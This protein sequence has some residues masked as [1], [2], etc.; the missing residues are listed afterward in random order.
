MK[1]LKG[2]VYLVGAGPGS[3]GLITVRGIEVLREA[4]VVLYDRLIHPYLL[5]FAPEARKIYCGKKPGKHVWDQERI[6][7]AL[8]REA[9]KEN[10]VVRLKGGD[11]FIFG[12]GGEE[13]I[14]LSRAQIPF[15]VVPG[16]SSA[17]GVPSSLGLPLTHRAKSSTLAIVTG[18]QDPTS[19]VLPIDWES[20]SSFETIVILM[21]VKALP[22][23]AKN[24]LKKKSPKTPVSIITWGTFPWQ[25]VVKGTL[26]NIVEKSQK[27]KVKPPSIIVVGKVVNLPCDLI[28]FKNFPH[29]GRRAFLIGSFDRVGDF[30]RRLID[31]GFQVEICNYKRELSDSLWKIV[32]TLGS[33]DWLIFKDPEAVEGLL[34]ALKEKKYDLRSLS[35]LGLGVMSE[36]ALEELKKSGLFADKVFSISEKFPARAIVIGS[37]E[38][39]G[40]GLEAKEISAFK[41]NLEPS[42]VKK[43][44]RKG[45]DFSFILSPSGVSVLSKIPG[46]RLGRVFAHSNCALPLREK[47]YSFIQF[48]S[49][50]QIEEF[51]YNY[52][53]EILKEVKL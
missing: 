22:E 42:I 39:G 16:I 50:S 20:V 38:N 35:N 29:M 32:A 19:P 7:T 33:F 47:N 24:I 49:F 6:N 36:E 34:L 26:R 46:N 23:I 40:E 14:A 37:Y 18:R 17:I 21:G 13:A 25:K 53:T 45:A 52:Q 12:R 43:V 51:F 11:P 44:N 30:G 2:K 31:L 9:R 15:E 5:N 10:I 41:I 48:D 1:G 3:P 8:I 4:D 28:S 27:E